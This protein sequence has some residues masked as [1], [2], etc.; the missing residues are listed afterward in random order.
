MPKMNGSGSK[1]FCLNFHFYHV[2]PFFC[3]LGWYHQSWVRWFNYLRH[4]KNPQAYR[5]HDILL[6]HAKAQRKGRVFKSPGNKTKPN[7]GAHLKTM[8]SFV[9]FNGYCIA[10]HLT[11]NGSQRDLR[12]SMDQMDTLPMDPTLAFG[13]IPALNEDDMSLGF[14]IYRC[15][16]SEVHYPRGTTTTRVRTKD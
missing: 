2:L 7:L 9:F 13:E 4:C 1:R 10:F 6:K 8:G 14:I 16:L 15:L 5:C 3:F 11:I 12:K